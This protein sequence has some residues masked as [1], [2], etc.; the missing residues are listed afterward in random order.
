MKAIALS[1]LVSC[2]CA[3]LVVV[4]YFINSYPHAPNSA[5]SPLTNVAVK[6]ANPVFP[7]VADANHQCSTT[8]QCDANG[9][10]QGQVS[11]NWGHNAGDAGW[12]CNA[13]I[14]QCGTVPGGCQAAYM[15][16]P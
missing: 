2:C 1:F 12:A 14:S 7:C 3:C 4:L 6:T 9:Q 16:A 15:S 11:I 5:L 13:W 8:W 10:R